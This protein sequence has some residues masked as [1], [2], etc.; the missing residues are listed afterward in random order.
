MYKDHTNKPN[1]NRNMY[2]DHM[3]KPN[4]NNNNAITNLVRV[5]RAASWTTPTTTSILLLIGSNERLRTTQD[6]DMK[7]IKIMEGI[8]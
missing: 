7:T 1:Y 8:V 2:K 3:N 4:D 6:G 5:D